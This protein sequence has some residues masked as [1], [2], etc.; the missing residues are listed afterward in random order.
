MKKLNG[1]LLTILGAVTLFSISSHVHVY[2]DGCDYIDED[3]YCVTV[4]NNSKEDEE[5]KPEDD[6][7]ETMY[8]IPQISVV[9]K[10]IETNPSDFDAYYEGEMSGYLEEYNRFSDDKSTLQGD[11][12]CYIN[13]RRNGATVDEAR[14]ECFK[15][16]PEKGFE[17]IAEELPKHEE[18]YKETIDII[19]NSD[20]LQGTL[21]KIWETIKSWFS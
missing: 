5:A 3:G 6:E 20:T 21:E 19:T 18:W 7:S 17:E 2:A 13:A 10:Q 11:K 15:Y 14:D 12:Q 4:I 16:N 9:D 8:Y 1:V